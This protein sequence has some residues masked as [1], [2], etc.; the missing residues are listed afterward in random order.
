MKDDSSNRL[1]AEKGETLHHGSYYIVIN[2]EY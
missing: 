1:I 2:I